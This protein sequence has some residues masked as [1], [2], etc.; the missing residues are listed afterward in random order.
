MPLKPAMDLIARAYEQG[1]AVGYFESWNFESLQG[2]VDAAEQTRSPVLIGF[3]GEFLSRKG[4][5]A[6]ERLPWYAALGRAAA[7]SA[8]VP[9]GLIFN[10]CSD[11]GWVRQAVDIG[12]SLVMPDDPKADADIFI[13]R[14]ADL[15][16][17][18][19]GRGVAVEAEVGQLPC[20][21]TGALGEGVT[22]LTDPGEAARFVAATGVDVLAISVGNVHI[23]LEGSQGLDVERL[24]AVRKAVKVPFD[25][26]GG[27]GIPADSLQAAIRHGVA[28]VCYGTYVKQR[29]IEALG[30]MFDA[31]APNPH[32]RLGWG[33]AEDFLVAVTK[34]AEGFGQC[35]DD[36]KTISD[37]VTPEDVENL[38]EFLQNI[39]LAAA[40]YDWEEIQLAANNFIACGQYI[41]RTS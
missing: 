2:V 18:A 29:Y 7:E 17:Y 5:L 21:A 11:D 32:K 9:C 24:A 20:G 30:P 31:A 33:G 10:E 38:P 3:N 25:L 14:V 39:S 22:G 4:R 23:M 34:M 36:L 27:T 41:Y 16:Q 1:Y 8:S 19:H 15:A 28:K 6:E 13:T 26:H 40:A 37:T 12:F 35:A